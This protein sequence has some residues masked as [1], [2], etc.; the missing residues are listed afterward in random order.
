MAT[1]RDRSAKGLSVLGPLL[2]I[3]PALTVAQTIPE[4]RVQASRPE[5]PATLDPIELFDAEFIA[6][7]DG[8]TADEVLAEVT[9]DLPGTEQ[10]VLIDGR[11]TQ[12]DI[13]T[14]PAEMIDHIEVSTTGQMPDGRP[15]VMG[16]VINVI[17]KKNYN[18]GTLA[19]RQRDS[20][21]GGATF[22]NLESIGRYQHR[23]RWFIQPMIGTPDPLH[24]TR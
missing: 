1:A 8:F 20:I 18:G 9:A 22:Q 19:A 11:E 10:I 14:I 5:A 15:P 6:Q 23:F 4:V 13:S 3:Y 12:V 16:N 2:L 7:T 21:E 17:L 24:Q